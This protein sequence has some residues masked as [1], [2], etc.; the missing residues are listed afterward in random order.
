AQNLTKL[1][2]AVSKI[3]KPIPERVFIECNTKG[4]ATFTF[5]SEG[6]IKTLQIKTKA[7]CF[8]NKTIQCSGT[9][10]IQAIKQQSKVNYASSNI[11]I[12]DGSVVLVVDGNTLDIGQYIE[13][14]QAP[15]LEAQTDHIS[16]PIFALKDSYSTCMN[17]LKFN[18]KACGVEANCGVSI[19]EKI[20]ITAYNERQVISNQYNAEAIQS[21]IVSKR[22]HFQLNK[23]QLNAIQ[24]MTDYVSQRSPLIPLTISKALVGSIIQIGNITIQTE[25]LYASLDGNENLQFALGNKALNVIDRILQSKAYPF[26]FI[27]SRSQLEYMLKTAKN[28]SATLD[29]K[30]LKISNDKLYIQ[31]IEAPMPKTKAIEIKN[32]TRKDASISI[33][34]ETLLSIIQSMKEEETIRL[35]MKDNKEGIW[36]STLNGESNHQTYAWVS[37][38]I[39]DLSNVKITKPID[40]MPEKM[41]MKEQ[42]TGMQ[43]FESELNT[44][45]I[46]AE[47][48]KVAKHDMEEVY[49]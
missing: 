28:L 16:I 32:A 25:I 35:S 24:T 49:A 5:I 22:K 18:S 39:G 48:E 31:C 12:Q 19:G 46:E 23:D 1:A 30:L 36:I 42:A 6:T 4:E 2:L 14:S 38:D 11:C 43:Q 8:S 40:A 13:G 41:P 21:Q 26:N 37:N 45:S 27:L 29:S 34:C 15:N 47:A 10:F 7:T 9:R 17:V 44:E 20:T 33:S 3:S